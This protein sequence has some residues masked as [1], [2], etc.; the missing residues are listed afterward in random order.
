[1]D[2]LANKLSGL[3]LSEK[4]ARIYIALLQLGAGTV[5]DLAHRTGIVRTT[6]YQLI[7]ELERKGLLSATRSGKRAVYV[8]ESPDVLIT[9][10]EQSLSRARAL[11]PSLSHL[12]EGNSKR[13]IIEI[14]D[15]IAGVWKFYEDVHQGQKLR[16]K[17]I[18]P[19]RRSDSHC[20]RQKSARIHQEACRKRDFN[21]SNYAENTFDRA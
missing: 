21:A 12:L 4:S 7:D 5:Q 18:Y 11:I 3:G 15:G 8:A 17:I 13:P 20:R 14:H 1:M 19:R 16:S 2:T 10:A 6:C 9:N